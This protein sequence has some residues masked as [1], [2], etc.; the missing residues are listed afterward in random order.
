[1]SSWFGPPGLMRP[2]SPPL[3]P[4][5]PRTPMTYTPGHRLYA[6]R[7]WPGTGFGASL[8]TGTLSIGTGVGVAK[9]FG[10]EVAKAFGVDVGGAS[11]PGASNA[12]TSQTPAPL[13]SPSSGRGKPRW[14]WGGHPSFVPPSMAGLP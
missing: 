7:V 8:S 3:N 4:T 1:M 11:S 13:P 12:P 14:S 9:G 5:T 6:S 10:V 2:V